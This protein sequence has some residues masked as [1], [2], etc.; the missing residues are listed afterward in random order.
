MALSHVRT[1]PCPLPPMHDCCARM[2]RPRYGLKKLCCG[3][4]ACPVPVGPVLMDVVRRSHIDTLRDGAFR[5]RVSLVLQHTRLRV[6]FPVQREQPVVHTP[7]HNTAQSRS[8]VYVCALLPGDGC[9]WLSLHSSP[10]GP[11]SRHGAAPAAEQE[12]SHET[13]ARHECPALSLSTGSAVFCGHT[14][15]TGDCVCRQCVLSWCVC[16]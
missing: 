1:A 10:Q 6:W 14:S 4:V 9:P 7:C 15:R 2:S 11:V 8:L 12:R 3:F 16:V 13:L 5:N